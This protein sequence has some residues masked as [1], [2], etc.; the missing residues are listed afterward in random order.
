MSNIMHIADRE[1]HMQEMRKES[2]G[3]LALLLTDA[4][5]ETTEQPVKVSLSVRDD[6]LKIQTSIEP[7]VCMP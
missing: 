4:L 5:R 6:F 1:L 2:Y 3:K 7:G